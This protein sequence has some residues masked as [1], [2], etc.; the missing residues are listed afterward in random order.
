[1]RRACVICNVPY[2]ILVVDDSHTIRR[3]VT[4]LLERRG[5]RVSATG[6]GAE[7]LSL[8][9]EGSEP[10]DLALVD[11]VM[12]RMNGLQLCRA[13]RERLRGRDLP[14]VL[15]SAKSD[16]IRDQFIA[17]TGAVDAISKPFDVDALVLVIEH[18]LRRSEAGIAVSVAYESGP[19]P[20]PPQ[21]LSQDVLT[22]S[23]ELIQTAITSMPLTVLANRDVLEGELR[24]RL[25]NPIDPLAG[26]IR[27]V[28]SASAHE[29]R[30][31]G[32]LG[33]F[34]LGSVLQWLQMDACTGVLLVRRKQREVSIC[35]RDG[36]IDLVQARRASRE[37]HLGRYFI[38]QGLV[39][40]EDID[41]LLR[42]IGSTPP[43]PPVSSGDE[44]P[45]SELN[46]MS[47]TNEHRTIGAL[48]VS[49][50]KATK[51]QLREALAR[52]SS[53]LIYDALRWSDGRFELSITSELPPLA[54]SAC[55]GL[56]VAAVVME[57][58]R[59]VDEWH[60][61]ERGL[62]DFTSV[63]QRDDTA[64]E[65][66]GRQRFV[67]QES[68]LL[69]LINGHRTV[70]DLVKESHMSSFETCKIL[71]QLLESRLVRRRTSEVA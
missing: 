47:T 6:D 65:A 58:L 19:P 56:P 2:H 52:Q 60:V 59:R 23:I 48:L 41:A 7:A 35:M 20:P 3:V 32:D 71:Y 12:P 26:A 51:E 27:A 50:G 66:A 17:Q 67:P 34:N 44:D 25:G 39:T 10:V 16:K 37:F 61:I 22:V 9:E 63:L 43:P 1:M 30:L 62:G 13:I 33:S 31:A 70:R 53:E 55:L 18:A 68:A 46:P 14:I 15:M 36:L 4:A 45:S 69:D 5:F 40:P 11:F 49:S 21:S 8:L 28:S 54:E 42:S 57:G 24:A 64:I 29:G 38:E